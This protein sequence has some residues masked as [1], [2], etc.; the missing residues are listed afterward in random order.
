[1]SLPEGVMYR[2]RGRIQLISSVP[3]SRH[4]SLPLAQL[5]LH[6]LLPISLSISLRLPIPGSC[7]SIRSNQAN[8]TPLWIEKFRI[9]WAFSWLIVPWLRPQTHQDHTFSLE[10]AQQALWCIF[11]VI[12]LY[13]PIS[14]VTTYGEIWP[15]PIK[16]LLI[17]G[18]YCSPYF[19]LQNFT[20]F[21]SKA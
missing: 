1:M 13:T 2:N 5:C 11:M 18:R 15:Y 14:Q 9:K 21:L 6:T 17:S 8:T 7:F 12:S 3:C 16:F 4:P 19:E 20:K 10:S